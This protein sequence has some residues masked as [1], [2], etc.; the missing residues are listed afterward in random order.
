M[1]S[2]YSSNSVLNGSSQQGAASAETSSTWRSGTWICLSAQ[3]R[4]IRTHGGVAEG[5]LAPSRYFL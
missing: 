5:L 2:Y 3:L 4:L 1:F